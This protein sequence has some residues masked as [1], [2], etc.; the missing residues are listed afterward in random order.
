MKN[1]TNH[2]KMENQKYKVALRWN[3]HKYKKKE[4]LNICK[5]YTYL[6]KK[7][8]WKDSFKT[9]LTLNHTPL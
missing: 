8:I 5:Y 3:N 4:T 9:N 2:T 7:T 1:K 6:T